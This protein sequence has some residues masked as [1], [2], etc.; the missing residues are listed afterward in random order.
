[1]IHARLIKNREIFAK[2]PMITTA[3]FNMIF[4]AATVINERKM[5]TSAGKRAIGRKTE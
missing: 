4:K 3:T 1:M 5:T 2:P